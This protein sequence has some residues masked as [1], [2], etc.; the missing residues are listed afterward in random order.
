ML[1][2]MSWVTYSV[3]AA[4]PAPQQLKEYNNEL[5][6][7]NKNTFN[8]ANWYFKLY[9]PRGTKQRVFSN[10]FISLI[11]RGITLVK[12]LGVCLWCKC[13]LASFLTKKKSK[14][15]KPHHKSF[16]VYLLNIWSNVVN[17]GTILISNNSILKNQKYSYYQALFSFFISLMLFSSLNNSMHKLI[18]TK[19]FFWHSLNSQLKLLPLVT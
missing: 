19:K 7:Q 14:Q 16:C 13:T 9:A 1:E 17:L 11:P 8:I 5:L 10:L 6:F 12:G 4:V 15:K 3:S 18:D 2:E